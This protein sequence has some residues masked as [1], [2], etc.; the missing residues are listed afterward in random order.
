MQQTNLIFNVAYALPLILA[1]GTLAADTA[2]PEPTTGAPVAKE[3][4]GKLPV[5]PTDVQ[6]RDARGKMFNIEDHPT[7]G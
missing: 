3:T 2:T 4:Q 7:P 1:A 5:G 6:V